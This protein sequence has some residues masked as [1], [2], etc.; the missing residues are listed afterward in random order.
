M[1]PVT[2]ARDVRNRRIH[3]HCVDVN[4]NN[5]NNLNPP[6]LKSLSQT[7]PRPVFWPSKSPAS[8]CIMSLQ[9]GLALVAVSEH[10]LFNAGRKVCAM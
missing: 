3:K 6:F 9:I 10:L 1:L 4:I 8:L 2:P 5:K 7:P